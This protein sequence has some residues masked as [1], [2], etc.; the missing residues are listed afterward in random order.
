MSWDG[1]FITKLRADWTTTFA[2]RPPFKFCATAGVRDEFVPRESSVE[3]FDESLRS[4]VAGD[5][6]EM[7]KP[8]VASADIVQLLLHLLVPSLQ[9]NR[10]GP[11]LCLR[12]KRL[13]TN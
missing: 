9:A 7:V 13:S 1:P 10:P 6:L 2:G 3:P 5:H 8:A 4:Y 12:I 11:Y